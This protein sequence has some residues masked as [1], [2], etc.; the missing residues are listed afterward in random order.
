[1]NDLLA[2][3]F[4]L[5]ARLAPGASMAD[6]ELAELR[7]F[8]AATLIQQ[9]PGFQPVVRSPAYDPAFNDAA[10]AGAELAASLGAAGTRLSFERQAY[11]APETGAQ[12]PS[13]TFGPFVDDNAAFVQFSVFETAPFVTVSADIDV[14]FVGVRMTTMRLPV[15]TA[16]DAA[17]ARRF[18]I[19]AG[20]VW[21]EGRAVSDAVGFIALRVTG[22]SLVF[23]APPAFVAGTSIDASI[24]VPW[25]LELEPEP[26]PPS[27]AAGNDADALAVVLPTRLVVRSDRTWRVDGALR[28]SGLG[29]DLDF[30]TQAGMA[31]VGGDSIAFPFDVG[32]AAWSIASNRSSAFALT[33][34]AVPVAGAVWQLPLFAGDITQVGE[35]ADGG[36]IGVLLRGAPLASRLAGASGACTCL[37]TVLT[38]SARGLEL[39]GRRASSSVAADALLWGTARSRL[40][41]GA[42]VL[43]GLRHASRRG[44]AD[45]A[46]L[47]GGRV[48]NAWDLPRAASGRPFAFDGNVDSV[49]LIVE[50]DGLRRIACAASV[51]QPDRETVRGF[52]LQNLFLHVHPARRAAF[53]GS[54]PGAW[55]A[56]EGAAKLWFDVRLAQPIL[57]DPY[58]ANW[59]V[60]HLDFRI[61]QSALGAVLRWPEG[62]APRLQASLDPLV[63]L[64]FPSARA[65]VEDANDL[66]LDPFRN[67]L[68]ARR[69]EL[70]L[71][72]VSS[73]DHLFG[74]AL[75]S[76]AEQPLRIDGANCLALPLHQVRLLMQPQVLWEPVDLPPPDPSPPNAPRT[77]L[78]SRTAGGTSLVGARTDTV[79]PVLPGRVCEEV[80]RA[81]RGAGPAAALFALPFGLRAFVRLESRLRGR[82]S[83]GIW[84]DLERHAFGTPGDDAMTGATALRMVA[85]G[86]LPFPPSAGD[87]P[88]PP[89]RGLP[90]RM[91]QTSNLE[92]GPP[93]GLQ[94]VLGPDIDTMVNDTFIGK[95]PVHQVD[96]SGYGLSAFSRWHLD[97]ADAIDL[98]GVTQVNFD[99]MLGRTA[100]EVIEVR[101]RMLFAQCRLVR[102]IVM[103]RRN[104][105]RVQ[106]FDSGWHAIDDG[107]FHRYVP[108]DTG[109]VT[110]LRNIRRIRILDRPHVGFNADGKAWEFQ[111]VVFDADAQVAD[112][113]TGGANGRVPI[114]DHPGW[115]QIKPIRPDPAPPPGV[116]PPDVPGQAVFE[117]L[118]AAVGGPVGGPMDCGIRLGQTLPM[119]LASLQVDLSR[120]P[121]PAIG[122]FFVAVYGAPALPRAAQWSVVRIDGKT[123]DVSPI[124]ARRGVPV[125][126]RRGE[127][128]YRFLDPVDAIASQPRA[129]YGLLMSA[130]ASRV[131]YPR[132]V[133]VPA[134][135]GAPGQVLTGAPL[136]ADAYALTQSS[137]TFPRPGFALVCGLDAAFSIAASGDWKA[138]VDDFP[139]SSSSR[140]PWTTATR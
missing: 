27:S 59:S 5:T 114:Y 111:A 121:L 63:P 21:L 81:A 89:N 42:P 62:A 70:A 65:T 16:I 96:L 23:D 132:P 107:E 6:G 1:M 99:V 66:L 83:T 37:D 139:I 52:A 135:G 7:R 11:L 98:V 71:L 8:I 129:T 51:A 58:A 78:L 124:D 93:A 108:F 119:Q 116:Q 74:V 125:I 94:N 67:H 9:N 100:Y 40:R 86:G 55:R 97:P 131:L 117:A 128:Q 12:R 82:P 54:G 130:T 26:A 123:S 43:A 91:I 53:A 31:V 2:Q 134:A 30:A 115:V 68:E 133:V 17:D 41:L 64:S 25:T 47:A 48:A 106:R 84:S 57:P 3:L 105:G 44:G 60:D 61:A 72:D 103:E 75:E 28:L 46:T 39:Q 95:V 136:V 29:S 10:A 87:R 56:S 69:T 77:Q 122:R 22:G 24:G 120:P 112:L 50:G 35:A 113:A 34:E 90:G 137:G 140:S 110:A 118:L 14:V 88:P 36:A 101:S 109:A 79:V 76:L 4:A 45:I 13:R 20:T 104:S 92:P 33:A 73:A 126:R 18:A 138:L 38:A 85:T 15:A 127:A 49:S 102:T 80:L 19:P 32:A